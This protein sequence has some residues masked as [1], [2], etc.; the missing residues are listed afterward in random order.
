MSN[1]DE[2]GVKNIGEKGEIRMTKEEVG[3]V[4]IGKNMRSYSG[5]DEHTVKDSVGRIE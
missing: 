4:V 2:I 5:E 3:I 1:N